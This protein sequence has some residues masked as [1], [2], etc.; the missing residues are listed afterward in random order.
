[1]C[2]YFSTFMADFRDNSSSFFGLKPLR[3]ILEI[4]SVAS[5]VVIISY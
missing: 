5:C 2:A 1:M 4:F 3:I